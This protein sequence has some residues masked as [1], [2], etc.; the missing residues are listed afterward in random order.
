MTQKRLSMSLQRNVQFLYESELAWLELEALGCCQIDWTIDRIRR[1]STALDGQPDQFR[2]RV[3]YIG[4]IEGRGTQYA[5]L[6]RPRYQGG[7]FNRT[8]S[9]NQYLTHWIYPYRG[10]YHPQMARALLNIIGVEPGEVV[11]D[12]YVGSGTTA[13][14]AMLLGVNCIGV[15]LSPL[16]VLLGSVKTQAH[17][18][19]GEIRQAVTELLQYEDLDPHNKQD[20]GNCSPDVVA[21]VEV[22]RMVSHSDIARRRRDG[23]AAF[24]RNLSGM[25]ESVEAQAAAVEEFSISVGEVSIVVGDARHLGRAGIG[26]ETIDGVVTSPPYSIALDYIKNDEHALRAMDVDLSQ[27][28]DQMTGLRGRGVRG[29]MDAYRRDMKAMFS[30]VA[31][32]LKRGRSA[33]FVI[34]DATVGGTEITTT[35][36]MVEWARAVGLQPI[37]ELAKIVFGLYSVMRDEK[38]LIFKK[39]GT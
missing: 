39:V 7:R 20:L 29:K 32:V 6:I 27:L 18:N 25:L 34:G 4:E 13:L 26:A 5:E 35:E 24:R 37:R 31:R 3:A 12:P 11:L 8:R 9:V 1:I 16:C 30:E 10:K 23:N 38:I 36:E 14:E 33:A 15:D 17:R 21:F 2:K 19:V 22:A 28:R